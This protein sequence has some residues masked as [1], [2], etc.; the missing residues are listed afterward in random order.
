MCVNFAAASQDGR[1]KEKMGEGV[2]QVYALEFACE[3]IEK[4]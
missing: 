2:G 1:I 4:R 3:E